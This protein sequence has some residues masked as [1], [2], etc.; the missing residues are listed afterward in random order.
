MR[1]LR[2][3]ILSASLLLSCVAWSQNVKIVIPAGTPEDKDLSAIAAENDAQKRIAS[4]EEFI[5]KYADNKPALAYGEW[6]LSIQYLSA[7]DAAKALAHGDKAL[8]LYPNNLDIIVSQAGVAQAMK[9]NSKV[10]DYA[11]QGAK[12]FHSIA[13][14]PK[15]ADVPDSDWPRQVKEEQDSA[16]SGYDFLEGAAYSAIA[17]EQDPAKRMAE[18]EKFT[19]AFPKS[20][21][22]TQVSQLALYSL[23]QL[24][25]P[26]RLVAYGEKALAANPDSV[27]TLLML[28]NA[29]VEDPKQA[30]KAVTYCNKV[31]ALTS[32]ANADKNQK[33]S[34]GLAHSTL[35][36]AYLKQDKLV[37]AVP[38]LKTAVSLLQDDP[39]G[40][41]AALFRLGWA[42]A[43]RNDKT[44][45]VAALQRAAAI[46]GPYQ[47]P[48]KEM[49]AKVNA[50]GKK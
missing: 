28:A 9:D 20:Q 18:I 19:P 49:L 11:V 10:V 48:A 8:E 23:Q 36:Y 50:A 22:E 34:A 37:A 46:D 21:Y 26:Q 44:D 32:G 27:P 15:P 31:I 39:P 14:Q 3:V 6:Q 24:N 45:A 7:G 35:G 40:Q 38:E 30:A 4:Y 17:A 41:Q 13:G 1:I 25:Q 47:G 2:Q 12:V 16:K 29:Y 42:Y 43:K 33:V 5:S